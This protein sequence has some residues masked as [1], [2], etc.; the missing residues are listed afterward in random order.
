MLPGS[1]RRAGPG[2][3]ALEVRNR[4]LPGER[5]I[6]QWDSGGTFTQWNA[7]E[8]DV[9]FVE[10]VRSIPIGRVSKVDCDYA[11]VKFPPLITAGSGDNSAQFEHR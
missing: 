11:A 4:R 9:I 2:H 10:D 5:Q 7:G 1:R 6:A 3:N 8:S